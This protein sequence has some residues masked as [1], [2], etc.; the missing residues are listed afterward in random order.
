MRGCHP[1]TIAPSKEDDEEEELEE[2]ELVALRLLFLC[3][4]P[5]LFFLLRLGLVLR[6]DGS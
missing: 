3:F 4:L 1:P 2:D 6:S 5:L